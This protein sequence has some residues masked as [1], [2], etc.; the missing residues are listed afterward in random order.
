M[1]VWIK[2]WGNLL[3]WVYFLETLIV[4]HTRR[5]LNIDNVFDRSIEGFQVFNHC[6]A[7][8]VEIGEGESDVVV[9]RPHI[10]VTSQIEERGSFK[11]Q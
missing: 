9:R 7:E 3:E 2:R 8:I 4:W 1:P 11:I 5:R 6:E 10:L